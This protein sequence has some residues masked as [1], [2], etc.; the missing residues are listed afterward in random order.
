MNEIETLAAD[1]AGAPLRVKLGVR[2]NL[3]VAGR[4]VRDDARAFA[5]GAHG[6]SAKHYPKSITHEVDAL[7]LACDIGP[8]LGGQGSLGHLF[9]LGVP[10]RGLPPHAHLGPALDRAAPGFEA[11]MADTGEASVW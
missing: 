3:E 9:E 8:E 4:G 6:G 5:P 1:L 11:S 10:S 2:V 7:G